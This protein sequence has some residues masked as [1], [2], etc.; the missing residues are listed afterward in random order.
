MW[1]CCGNVYENSKRHLEVLKSSWIKTLSRMPKSFE[2]WACYNQG[3]RSPINV[4]SL[5]NQESFLW[6]KQSNVFL[7]R[8]SGKKTPRFKEENFH[9][10]QVGSRTKPPG[11][12]FWKVS[13]FDEEKRQK[14]R[15]RFCSLEIFF[16][17]IEILKLDLETTAPCC[18]A[19]SVGKEGK[20]VAKTQRDHWSGSGMTASLLK[21]VLTQAPNKKNEFFCLSSLGV[22]VPRI[23]KNVLFC[24]FSWKEFF[25]MCEEFYQQYGGAGGMD[26]DDFD[27]D[28]LPDHDEL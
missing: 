26:D 13:F 11:N 3:L 17:W 15:D 16:F 20:N 21:N 10:K 27:D 1:Q 23:M 19:T 22:R 2:C 14:Q 24:C 12:L 7:E 25:Y 6:V 4:H 28:D 8:Y 5:G 18:H 9:H